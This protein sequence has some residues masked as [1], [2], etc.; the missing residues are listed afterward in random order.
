MAAAF[1]LC[2]IP[3]VAFAAGAAD[4]LQNF[5][6]TYRCAVVERLELTHA[7]ADQAGKGEFLILA[8]RSARE[9]YV[10][11]IFHDKDTAIFCEAA[12]GFYK[13]PV[14]RT[15]DANAMAA[16]KRLGFQP[17]VRRA[18]TRETYKASRVLTFPESPT[19]F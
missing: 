1:L 4:G 15:L 2:G 13:P 14:W 12:S 6:A 7:R 3:S 8:P 11:C 16:L 10:Q 19:S 18:T 5:L 9:R 17:I